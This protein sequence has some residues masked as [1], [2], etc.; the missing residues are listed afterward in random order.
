M[1][2]AMFRTRSFLFGSP[3]D[4]QLIARAAAVKAD[5]VH[6]DLADSIPAPQKESARKSLEEVLFDQCEIPTAIRINS[7]ETADGVR[8]MN[9][10]SEKKLTPSILIFPKLTDIAHLQSAVSKMQ[11][12]GIVAKIFAVVENTQFLRQLGKLKEA[13][14]A[15]DGVIFGAVDFCADLGIPFS[16]ASTLPIRF[17][18]GTIAK[19]FGIR[20]I[21]S[22]CFPADH[23]T[24]LIRQ[25][26]EARS[27]G[28]D[29]KIAMTPSQVPI[30]NE[31]FQVE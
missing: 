18:I 4:K 19:R 15:L 23:E 13:P 6:F 27:L 17:E 30:I 2:V 10:L 7:I 9:F 11:M 1:G 31:V 26:Q 12:S 24:E 3:C 20:L 22:P 29:G 5:V 8:D 16:H 28:Y 25:T 21:D 14:S